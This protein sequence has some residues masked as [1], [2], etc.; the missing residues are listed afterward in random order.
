MDFEEYKKIYFNTTFALDRTMLTALISSRMM[1]DFPKNLSTRIGNEIKEVLNVL[2]SR[3]KILIDYKE[4][5][6]SHKEY[7]KLLP[8][9]NLSFPIK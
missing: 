1:D 7:D 9:P 4:S 3:I 5:I 2:T 6:I 8:R